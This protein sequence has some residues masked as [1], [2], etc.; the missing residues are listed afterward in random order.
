MWDRFKDL[1][2]YFCNV[3]TEIRYEMMKIN[4]LIHDPF[5][6]D[7]DLKYRCNICD[8]VYKPRYITIQHHQYENIIHKKNVDVLLEKYKELEEL[9][10][11]Y[12][13]KNDFY[14]EQSIFYM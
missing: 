6:Y 11:L 9:I 12:N 4:M 7:K 5:S 3:L 14:N 1:Y 13:E 10:D 8:K 2:Y